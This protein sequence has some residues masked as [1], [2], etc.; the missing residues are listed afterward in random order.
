LLSFAQPRQIDARARAAL[1]CTS[2][3]PRRQEPAMAAKWGDIVEDELG[4][5]AAGRGMGGGHDGCV[6]RSVEVA[7]SAGRVLQPNNQA[8]AY[9]L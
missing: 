6:W 1:R 2:R 3:A 5:S 8:K 9:I 4:Q 7:R